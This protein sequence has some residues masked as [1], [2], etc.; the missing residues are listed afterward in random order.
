MALLWR[1]NLIKNEESTFKWNF[2]IFIQKLRFLEK[3]TEY[4]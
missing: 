4:F 3:Y 2:H 1:L